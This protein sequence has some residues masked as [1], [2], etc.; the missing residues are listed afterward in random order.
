[1]KL[2]INRIYPPDFTR[3]Q[4]CVVYTKTGEILTKNYKYYKAKE[5][6]S[7]SSA[8]LPPTQTD[9]C[10]NTLFFLVLLSLMNQ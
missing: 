10:L 1:M 7:V 3:H 9:C 5:K 4:K 8:K 6:C 2:E